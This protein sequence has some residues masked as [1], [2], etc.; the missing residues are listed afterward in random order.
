[1]TV[2]KKKIGQKKILGFEYGQ[3]YA[4]QLLGDVNENITKNFLKWRE[5]QAKLCNLF[6]ENL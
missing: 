3:A 6:Q 1:M 4:S 5:N 2:G